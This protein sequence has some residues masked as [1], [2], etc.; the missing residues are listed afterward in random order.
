M[1]FNSYQREN[2][3]SNKYQYNGKELQSELGLNWNDYGPRMYMSD[4]GRWGVV[5]PLADQ[6]RR[7]S[8]YNYAFDN[9]VRYIDP[10]GMAPFTEIYNTSGKKIGQDAA[11]NDGN[12]SVVKNDDDANRIEKDYKSNKI[13]SEADVNAG[14][15]TTKAVLSESLDVLNR[16]EDNGGL[17]EERSI[18]TSSGEVIKAETGSEPTYSQ[19]QGVNVQTASAGSITV[20]PGTN[21]GGATQIHSHPTKVAE[22]N[23]QYFP[24]SAS[25]PSF[26]QD[27]TAFAA[28]KTNVIVGKL[29][30]LK[31]INLNSDGSVNDTRKSGAEFYGSNLSKSQLTLTESAMKRIVK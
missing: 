22:H 27:R 28:T 17:R 11:G 1:T 24:Q 14:Y 4:I 16:T 9:P 31:T 18:V 15:K 26:P 29:G 3:V 5:D 13:A 25:Q 30:L 2:S 21:L 7:H 19:V 20:A 23:G 8:P 6:M 10:D 12:V